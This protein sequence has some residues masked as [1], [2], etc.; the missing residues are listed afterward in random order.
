MAHEV[1]EDPGDRS[2]DGDE[3]QGPE[4]G[5]GELDR[6]GDVGVAGKAIPL[7]MIAVSQDGDHAGALDAGR[8]IER[9]VGKSVLLELLYPILARGDHVLLGSKL[10]AAGRARLDTSRLEADLDPIHA[11]RALGH[12][13]RCLVELRNLER[14]SSRPQAPA[15]A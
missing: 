10:E 6:P 4:D 13:P 1:P 2:E 7:R 14:P 5:L 12:F 3:P 15:L 9:R 8:I 11:Q